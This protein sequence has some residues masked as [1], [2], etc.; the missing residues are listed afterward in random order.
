[1]DLSHEQIEYHMMC[2]WANFCDKPQDFAILGWY[3]S[4]VCLDLPSKVPCFSY[5][6]Q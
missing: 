6:V 1:M 5:M 2:I 3:R 4:Y